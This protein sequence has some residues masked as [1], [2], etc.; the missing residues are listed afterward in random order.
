ME[1]WTSVQRSPETTEKY[2]MELL[3]IFTFVT[4]LLIYIWATRKE[5]LYLGG[6]INGKISNFFFEIG[7]ITEWVSKGREEACGMLQNDARHMASARACLFR[8]RSWNYTILA[9]EPRD[10]LG[11]HQEPR[12]TENENIDF[13]NDLI[14]FAGSLFFPPVKWQWWDT[15]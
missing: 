7:S 12:C 15:S 14:T 4:I 2:S 10:L 6:S 5:C 1:I 11:Q 13:S 9:H 3:T 8:F